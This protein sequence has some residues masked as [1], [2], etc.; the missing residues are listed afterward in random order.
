MSYRTVKNKF[1]KECLKGT[2]AQKFIVRFS[3]FFGIIQQETRL[4]PR[5]SKM[6]LNPSI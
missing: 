5:I 4:R 2:Q 1:L 3:Q 6:L